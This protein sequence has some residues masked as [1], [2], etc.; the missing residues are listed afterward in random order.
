MTLYSSLFAMLVVHI[1]VAVNEEVIL[2]V[3]AQGTVWDDKPRLWLPKLLY[4]RILLFVVDVVILV[5]ATWAVFNEGTVA[6]LASCTPYTTAL[7]FSK[8]IV[9]VMWITLAI[10]SVG[11]LI[12]SD[13]CGCFS[14][15]SLLAELQPVNDKHERQ[16]RVF[17]RLRILCSLFCVKGTRETTL[18]LRD[19]AHSMQELFHNVDLVPS[20]L[21]VGFLQVRRDQKKKKMERGVADLLTPLRE[22][23]NQFP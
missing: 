7:K 6:Q 12:F 15:T 14:G 9:T 11:M 17:R 18:A 22:V 13:P 2:L 20:D 1:L 21:L 4:L 5:Y 3:S 10:Y 23:G 8:A 16:R 19:L